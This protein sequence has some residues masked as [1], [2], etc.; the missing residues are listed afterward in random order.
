M[1]DAQLI[2]PDKAFAQEIMGLGGDSL[3]KCFQCATCSVVC[4]VS[5]EH[6]PFPRKEMLWAQ[7]GLKEK[8]FAD[9]DLWLC[10]RCNDCS[11]H[12]P[13]GASPGDV[14]A[15]VRD[16]C[17]QHYAV[18][19][20][21]GQAFRRGGLVPLLLAIPA[22]LLLG[23]ILGFGD[24]TPQGDVEYS[25]FFPHTALIIFFTGF[26]ALTAIAIVTSVI[27]F[28]RDLERQA[29]PGR[30]DSL[31]ASV[32]SGAKEI[33]SHRQFRECTQR[34]SRSWSHLLTFYGFLG[35]LFTTGAVVASK[36]VFQYY[37][38]DWWHPL[39]WIG[40]FST[41]VIFTGLTWILVERL[42]G[43]EHAEKST[44]YDW[45]FILILYLVVITG[46]ITEVLRFANVAGPAY[47]VYFVHMVVVFFLLVYVAYSRFAHMIYRTVAI[48]HAK[49]S[50]REDSVVA[51]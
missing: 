13:R 50:G 16:R 33:L 40:N 34:H 18:P 6:R 26:T 19:R 3:Q 35:L 51:K 2:K 22:L 43:G 5:P 41:L 37:P 17:I 38:I 47:A 11:V 39:K 12:C 4:G 27:R 10:H 7:W 14:M 25:H 44:V 1:S 48:F 15:A 23:A 31:V 46:I 42:R 20:F 24:L 21:L 29:P 49:Y 28:W 45:S 32:V 36:Y 9:P 8:L 30:R